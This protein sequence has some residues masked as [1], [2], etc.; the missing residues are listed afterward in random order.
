MKSFWEELLTPFTVLA[1]MEGVTDV[2]FRQIVTQIG[3][4]DVFVTEFTST[5]GLMSPGREKVAESLK[6]GEN[7]RPIVAQ[8]WGVSPEMFFDSAKYCKTLGF[9]GIDINMGCPVRKIMR[10]GACAGLINNPSFAKEIIQATKEGASGLPVS[11]KTRIGFGDQNINE[12]IGFL[13]DQDLPALTIHLRT[14]KELSKVPAH[15]E[16]LSE[17]VT[18][19]NKISPKTLII[20]NGDI[21]SFTEIEEKYNQYGCEGF[22][23]GRGVFTNPWLFNKGVM[24]ENVTSLKRLD[25]YVQHIQLYEKTWGMQKNSAN[26]KKFCKTYVTNFSDAAMIREKI[27]QAKNIQEMIDIITAY[28]KLQMHVF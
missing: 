15:W 27:M 14:A 12:W 6:F 17:I 8:L 21:T 10:D 2:V 4:P 24:I 9:S 1:P 28:K 13:F 7:E 19:R 3:K 22:M 5:D 26:L 25:L 11:V 18:L 23:V 16:Y 20:G